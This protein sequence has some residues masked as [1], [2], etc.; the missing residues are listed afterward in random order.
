M[1]SREGCDEIDLVPL[2]KGT[3]RFANSE[4]YPADYPGCESG[5]PSALVIRLTTAITNKHRMK[6]AETE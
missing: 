4:I 3:C 5:R 2:G 6:I 1:Y